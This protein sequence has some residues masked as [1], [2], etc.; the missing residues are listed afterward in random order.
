M[1]KQMALLFSVVRTAGAGLLAALALSAHAEGRKVPVTMIDGLPVIA[2]QLGAVKVDFLLDTGG[3]IGITVPDPLITGATKVALS[4]GEQ[5]MT[6]AAGHVYLVRKVVAQSVRVGDAELG[7]VDGLVNYQWGLSVGKEGAPEVTKKGVIGLKAL[8]IKNVLFDIAA[9]SVSLYD[10]GTQ[11][12]DVSGWKRA[13]FEYDARGVVLRIVVNGVGA[14]MSL[15]TAATN[16]MIR[17]DAKL[18]SKTRSP[19]VGKKPDASFCGMATLKVDAEGQEP[20]VGSIEAAV[21]QMGAV[22]FDGLL[23]IDFFQSR[24]VYLDFE[25]STAFIQDVPR[26]RGKK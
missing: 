15:D 26:R 25:S 22:P 17:K 2:V 23:G 13:K 12:P 20:G 7:P 6:D 14:A 4:G 1:Q 3:Q 5:K 9:G 24:R 21:V 10:R 18:F 8:A 16:S 19:C 11:G